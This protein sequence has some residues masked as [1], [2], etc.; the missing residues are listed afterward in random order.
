M[1]QEKIPLGVA[2]YQLCCV[3]DCGKDAISEI[4]FETPAGKIWLGCCGNEA[5][6][7]VIY[8]L[9]DLRKLKQGVRNKRVVFEQVFVQPPQADFKCKMQRETANLPNTQAN[10]RKDATDL[11]CKPDAA[12]LMSKD[13]RWVFSYRRWCNI[14]GTP[15]SM[16]ALKDHEI[17]SAVHGIVTSTY[18]RLPQKLSWVQNVPHLEPPVVYPPKVLFAHK[19]HARDKLEEF[20]SELISRKILQ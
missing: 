19:R 18:K 12:V 15:V 4:G 16:M 6:R 20:H 10:R 3:F 14:Q 9:G 5:H 7:D 1:T 2:K 11:H 8:S 17:T 13:F